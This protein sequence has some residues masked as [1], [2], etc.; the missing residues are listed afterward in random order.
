M[1]IINGTTGSETL[2][3]TDEEDVI[4]GRSG[5]DR[6]VGLP[7]D[8]ILRGGVGDDTLIGSAGDDSLVGFAGADDLRAGNG[9]DSANGEDGDDSVHGG[10]GD[11][12]VRGGAG[13]D[14]VKGGDGDDVVRGDNGDDIVRGDDGDDNVFGGRGAD[15]VVGGRGD[16]MVSGGSGAD[17]VRGGNG[18][19]K[20]RGDNGDDTVEGGK[21]D[22][23]LFGGNGRDQFAFN[24][25][26]S[27]EGDDRIRDFELGV[28]KIV[29]NVGDV[30]AATPGLAQFIVSNGGD[31]AAVLAGLDDS[32]DWAL[33]ANNKGEAVITHPNGTITL[34]GI[35][36]AGISSFA[37]VAA[38]LTV[39]GLG[40]ALSGLADASGNP[41]TIADVVAASGGT[42]DNNS[43]DFDLLGIA[44]DAAGLTGAVADE[45]ALL[46]V[47]A[48]TDAAFISLAQRLGFQGSDEAGAIGSIIDTLTTL[49]NGDPI[50]LLTDILLYHVAGGASTLGELQADRDITPLFDAADFTI[51]GTTVIDQDD[52]FDD[53]TIIASD[54]QTGNG[55]IQVIDEV[56]LP[57]DV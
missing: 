48:P 8:D 42:P 16:D 22:D 40:E 44:L 3:G 57:F 54:I 9:D 19:D 31:V 11:D 20:I 17:F 51:D 7:G 46:T 12:E 1:A 10:S 29:L 13:D 18:N 2:T 5:D 32:E 4:R 21:G 30:L 39:T 36:A 50:P 28:D 26:R 23:I 27:D 47:L 56:I 41:S 37:D 15:L 52:D 6:I 49:G 14:T 55:V 43:G 33:G 34:D 45:D 38:A 25:N 24:P 35:P 53:A